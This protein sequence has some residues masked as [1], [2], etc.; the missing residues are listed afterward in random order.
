MAASNH[1]GEVLRVYPS[2]TIDEGWWSPEY[3]DIE[4]PRGWEFLPA[5]DAFVTREVKRRGPCWVVVRAREGYT[6]TLGL[7]APRTSI[8]AAR[9][10]AEETAADR[11]A[12]RERSRLRR[13]DQQRAYARQFAEAVLRFLGFAPRYRVMAEEIAQGAAERATA[14]GSGRVGRT[15]K[16]SLEAKA[17]LAARAYIRHR[18]TSY[19]E[20]LI[21]EGLFDLDTLTYH[22]VRTQAREE[23]DEFLERHRR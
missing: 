9:A 1:A 21:E 5:G 3:G 16:L 11:E 23:V 2:R 20:R 18:H 7:L 14:V 19:E 4:A 17:E 15:A 6:Q 10:E 13:E 12:T 8:Q 22:D